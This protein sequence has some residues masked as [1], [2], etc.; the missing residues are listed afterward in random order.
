MMFRVG[1]KCPVF[2]LD[3]DAILNI[4]IFLYVVFNGVLLLLCGLGR[5]CEVRRSGVC[6]PPAGV[7][8]SGAPGDEHRLQA[9][10]RDV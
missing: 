4:N 2:D 7:S 6:L 9:G 1:G 5:V 3:P 8:G 10:Q